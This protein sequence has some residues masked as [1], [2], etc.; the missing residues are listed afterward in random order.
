MLC[1]TECNRLRNHLNKVNKYEQTNYFL[2]NPKNFKAFNNQYKLKNTI[3]NKNKTLVFQKVFLLQEKSKE[4][5][6][7]FC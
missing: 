5:V 3:H 7:F 2:N 1:T 4:R 6:F